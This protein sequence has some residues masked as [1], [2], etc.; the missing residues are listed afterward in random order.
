MFSLK[1]VRFVASWVSLDVEAR[2]VRSAL[3]QSCRRASSRAGA[4]W[5]GPFVDCRRQD[6]PHAAR[7]RE[8]R[9]RSWLNGPNTRYLF[10]NGMIRVN[11]GS[12]RMGVTVHRRGAGVAPR[13][14]IPAGAAG[15]PVKLAVVSRMIAPKGIAEAVEAVRQARAAGASVELDLYGEPDPAN[16]LSITG[17]HVACVGSQPGIRWHGRTEEIAWGLAGSTTSRCS[18]RPTAKACRARSSKPRRRPSDHCLRD[19]GMP[20][21]HS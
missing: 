8:A 10:E 21:P 19:T 5:L 18:C 7:G 15:P 6:D 14:S 4:D 2:S 16:P 20:R 13:I 11:S 9:D 1:R 3:G 17:G 12:I